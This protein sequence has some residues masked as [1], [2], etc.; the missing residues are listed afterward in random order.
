MTSQ[1][2][3]PPSIPVVQNCE[4]LALPPTSTEIWLW[5][6]GVGGQT[7]A[8]DPPPPRPPTDT[9]L[10]PDAVL[11]HCVQRSV[12]RVGARLLIQVLEA[13]AGSEAT[14][15]A[16]LGDIQLP[17]KAQ[18]ARALLVGEQHRVAVVALGGKWWSC[19]E[20]RSVEPTLQPSPTHR[21][22]QAALGDEGDG[23]ERKGLSAQ[24]GNAEREGQSVSGELRPF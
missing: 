9:P 8:P 19:S 2:L 21:G 24:G 10:A 3:M 12:G 5:S 18:G 4:Q 11:V 17:P 6:T 23:Q 1:M 16:L 20:S 7:A 14:L 15:G 13:L 22:H